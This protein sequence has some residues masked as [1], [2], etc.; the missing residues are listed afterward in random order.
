MGQFNFY[1]TW[2]DS[3]AYLELLVRMEQFT[4]V[5]DMWYTQPVPLQFM[6]L[7][8]EVKAAVRK[9]PR[10][11]LWCDRYSQFPPGFREPTPNGLM[12][13][14]PTKSG[15]ALDLG[16]PVRFERNGQL[17]VGLGDLFYQPIYYEPR[18]REPYAPPEALK[19][20]YNEVRTLLRKNMMKRYIRSQMITSKNIT[21]TTIETLW[22]G[23]DAMALLESGAVKILVNGEL[24]S[25]A[26][27]SKTR[28]T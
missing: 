1:G 26:E 22:I 25:G 24:R 5:I 20:T 18:T 8:N 28:P 7:T 27:L 3:L 14:D 17:G 10:V 11:Y 2:N 12:M 21:K 19:Q 16:L 13:I 23:S 15:P 6:T 4:F 9:R